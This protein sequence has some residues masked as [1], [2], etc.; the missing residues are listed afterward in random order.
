[1]KREHRKEL[2][3]AAGVIAIVVSLLFLAMETRQNTNALYA[4]SRQAVLAASQAELFATVDHPEIIGAVVKDGPMTEDEQIKVGAWLA[5][6]MRAREFS[7]LQYR[8]EI[9]DK[10][11][12]DTELAII[13][14]ILDTPRTRDWWEHTGKFAVS[15][16]FASFVDSEIRKRPEPTDAWS[17]E[18]NWAKQRPAGD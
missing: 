5:A 7:W 9:I 8:D 2:F 4:G 16:E 18:T 12:W 6:A 3:E 15:S 17:R 1:M 14:W 10:A 13:H 11:Q